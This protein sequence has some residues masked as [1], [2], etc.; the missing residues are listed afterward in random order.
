MVTRLLLLKGTRTQ[1]PFVPNTHAMKSVNRLADHTLIAK[2]ERRHGN[3]LKAASAVCVPGPPTGSPC[4][5]A[6]LRRQPARG[7]D[8]MIQVQAGALSRHGS[9]VPATLVG[10]S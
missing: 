5:S 10:Y 2:V 3:W 6:T 1:H 8:G 7:S 9:T 4:P